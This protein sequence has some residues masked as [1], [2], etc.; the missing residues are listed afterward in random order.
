VA[1][2]RAE[3]DNC[4]REAVFGLLGKLAE[5]TEGSFRTD[6]HA[7]FADDAHGVALAVLTASRGGR[8]FELNE[9]HVF[10]LRD[11]KV[12]EFWIAPTDQYALDEL[13]R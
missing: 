12:V 1:R 4:G 13:L 11:G 9:A 10:H 8:S 7:V 2:R 6:L 3:P 5:L